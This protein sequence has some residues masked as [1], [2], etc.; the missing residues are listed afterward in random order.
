MELLEKIFDVIEDLAGYYTYG[1]PV[2][3]VTIHNTLSELH[4]ECHGTDN[5]MEYYYYD[6]TNDADK[7]N[8]YVI[9][10]RYKHKTIKDAR[11]DFMA[12]L[13]KTENYN[14]NNKECLI[15]NIKTN[16]HEL[17]NKYYGEV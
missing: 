1:I 7:I 6:F 16:S 11:Y 5:I 9:I 12:F 8:D 17:L 15:V 2:N 3:P 4:E 13:E 14:K 10:I